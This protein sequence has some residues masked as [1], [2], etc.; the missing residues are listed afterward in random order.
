[1][2]ELSGANLDIEY[3]GPLA[4]SQ[5]ATRL[6]GFEE[7]LRIMA[8]VAQLQPAVM[9]NLDFDAAARDLAEV[10]G[11]PALYLRDQEQIEAVRQQ[12]QTEQ[13]MANK[14]QV[15]GGAA[16]AAGKMAPAISAI[17]DAGGMQGLAGGMPEEMQQ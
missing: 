4:R 13:E 9:D 10:A 16:E 2:P 12:R 14:L 17:S 3:E 6:A 7:Y 5:K 15:A 8:P 11:L 1:P